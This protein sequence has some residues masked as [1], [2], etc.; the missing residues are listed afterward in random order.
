MVGGGAPKKVTTDNQ[1][2][3][4]T[5]HHLLT[6]NPIVHPVEDMSMFITTC[7]SHDRYERPT[8]AATLTGKEHL[9]T[10]C[11]YPAT[12]LRQGIPPTIFTRNGI[13]GKSHRLAPKEVALLVP[14]KFRTLANKTKLL[15]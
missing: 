5:T 11:R 14:F 15:S 7:P 8:S 4:I 1:N 10:P 2:P 12:M 6:A 13:F 9:F 3:L